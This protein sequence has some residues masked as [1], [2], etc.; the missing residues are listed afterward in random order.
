LLFGVRTGKSEAQIQQDRDAVLKR[1]NADGGW[2][3][4]KDLPSDA[5]ATGQALWVL[6]FAA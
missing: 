2:S 6:S 4:L 5:Y 1:Q 3:P